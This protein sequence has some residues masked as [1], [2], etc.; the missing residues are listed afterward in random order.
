MNAA[1][2]APGAGVEVEVSCDATGAWVRV[3]DH[4]AGI[5]AD[6]QGKIFDRFRRAHPEGSAGGTGLGL[7]IARGIV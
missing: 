4:G 1:K 2:Y 6:Q 3:G 7:Y 5:P